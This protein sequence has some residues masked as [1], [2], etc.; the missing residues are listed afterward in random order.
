MYASYKKIAMIVLYK[1]L[2]QTI[3]NLKNHSKYSHLLLVKLETSEDSLYNSNN[4]S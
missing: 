2:V 4:V 3:N 1:Y